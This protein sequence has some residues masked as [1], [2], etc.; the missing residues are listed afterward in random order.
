MMRV[1]DELLHAAD[2]RL[3][4]QSAL[5]EIACLDREIGTWFQ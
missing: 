1:A 5:D 4:A 3:L 2:D